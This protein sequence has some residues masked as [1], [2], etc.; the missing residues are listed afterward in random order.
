MAICINLY[1]AKNY[2][3]IMHAYDCIEDCIMYNLTFESTLHDS[4]SA[5]SGKA[6]AIS[7]EETSGLYWDK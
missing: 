7:V 3:R 6:S 2:I 5:G 4:N 1:K